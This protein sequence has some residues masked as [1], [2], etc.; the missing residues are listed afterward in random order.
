MFYGSSLA[1]VVV[2]GSWHMK[3][4]DPF[5]RLA[6]MSFAAKLDLVYIYF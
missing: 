3:S 4:L 6:R 5:S 1:V 2:L